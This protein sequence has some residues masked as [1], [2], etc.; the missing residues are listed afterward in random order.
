MDKNFVFEKLNNFSPDWIKK[1]DPSQSVTEILQ[2]TLSQVLPGLIGMKVEYLDDEKIIG[3]VPYSHQTANVVG[4]M[5]GG[6]I[7]T[8]GDSLA[9]TF[10][11]TKSEA[12][13]YAITIRSEI[14][15]LKPFKQG[16]LKC[17]VTEKSR[18]DRVVVLE[19]IF[20]DENNQIISTMILDFLLMT[21]DCS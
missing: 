10:L 13:Q 12:N 11:W 20:E 6:T 5:H 17:T 2:Q 3:T 21:I 18:K 9:G 1:A 19:A 4:Y 14:K 8:T 7:F 16:V 15:Y